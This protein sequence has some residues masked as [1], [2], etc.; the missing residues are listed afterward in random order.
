MPIPR[1]DIDRCSLSWAA[2]VVC[3]GIW[4]TG[5][6]GPD[7][8]A[9]SAGWMASGP[10]QRR[11][12]GVAKSVAPLL[13]GLTVEHDVSR[14]LVS[15]TRNRKQGL[16]RFTG[17]QG[18]IVIDHE[19]APLHFT[20]TPV[21]ARP[22]ASDDQ[23]WPRGEIVPEA[24]LTMQQR[25]GVG[26]A[27]DLLFADA[28]QMT[29][30]V[31]VVHK[32]KIVGERYRRPYS[33]NSRFESWSMGKCIAA[34]L[35]G[36]LERRGEVDLSQP[37]PF[38]EWSA[39][40]DPRRN[41]HLADVLQMSSGIEFTGSYGRGEDHAVRDIGGRYLDHIYVYA[42]GVD[43]HAYCSGKPA[44]HPPGTVG[45]YRNCD[46]LLA[47][48]LVKQ[49]VEARGEEFLTWPQRNLFDPLGMRGMVLE[50]DPYGNFLISGH[51][52]GRARDWARLGLLHLN[53]GAWFGDQIL[54]ESFCEFM[55]TP[56]KAWPEPF[57][58]GF[59]YLN[60]SGIMPSLPRDAYWASGGG[61]QRTL[62]VPSA[63]LVVV[64]LG[65]LSGQ[66]RDPLATLDVAV[67][68]I[69]DALR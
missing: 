24:R 46:P 56:A 32:G 5:R 63:D 26:E 39:P 65:H 61:F 13:E 44:E 47:M 40:D 41:I 2:K 23:R 17:P 25:T 27:L 10:E 15:V 53:R 67:A 57:Y 6:E 50:T 20:P 34:T 66:L 51:D 49:I 60:R 12:A 48:K 58:G 59:V 68:K 33:E 4:I 1:D 22:T 37:M 16:A 8:L 36:V 31:V 30:A 14:R 9:G 43:A 42:G 35:I 21:T 55:R 38:A 3:S 52:Y 54:N 45:R 62:I 69:I 28:G 18:A 11:A 64:R 7:V 19:D 29:N